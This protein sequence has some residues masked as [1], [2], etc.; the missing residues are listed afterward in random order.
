MSVRHTYTP[1]K[2]AVQ[3]FTDRTSI[4]IQLF[5]VSPVK[6]LF[7]QR[8]THWQDLPESR[9]LILWVHC[10]EFITC[11]HMN[12]LAF[13]CP[14]VQACCSH[15]SIHSSREKIAA[16]AWEHVCTLPQCVAC[17]VSAAELD[18][19][20]RR[21]TDRR[22]LACW[23]LPRPSPHRFWPLVQMQAQPLNPPLSSLRDEEPGRFLNDDFKH[24]F[25]KRLSFA[26]CEIA[27][28]TLWK[29]LDTCR[30]NEIVLNIDIAPTILGLAGIDAPPGM[31]GRN[32]LPLLRRWESP[33]LTCFIPSF[34]AKPNV[35]RK[36]LYFLCDVRFGSWG[37]LVVVWVSLIFIDV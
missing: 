29:D 31:D 20:V 19:C 16:I 3:R 25:E 17:C 6:H 14:N 24:A 26:I 4:I 21:V 13:R 22:A 7:A 33:A 27:L 28:G 34:D 18:W 10:S 5:W 36:N 1:V 15:P 9:L 12:M 2:T 23:P 37:W 30:M 35:R 8:C 11:V 32:F